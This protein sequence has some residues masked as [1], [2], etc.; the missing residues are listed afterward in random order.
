MY[1]AK[2]MKMILLQDNK[3]LGK[4]GDLVTVSDGFAF[5]SLIP[6]KIAKPAT[7]QVIAAVK[8]D[9]IK[10]QKEFDAMKERLREDAKRIDKKNVTVYAKAKGNKLFG[11]VTQK[12]I[13]GAIS[14]Q[15]GVKVSEKS[16]LLKTAIKELTTCEVRIDYG[17][18][19]SAGII[20][21][22]VSK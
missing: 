16:V 18:A 19:I 3:K 12:D 1:N 5:N 8:R 4:K 15:L 17:H 11:S 7:E 2:R 14:E 22:V 21:T 9:E 10:K 6:Q 13:A 20:V